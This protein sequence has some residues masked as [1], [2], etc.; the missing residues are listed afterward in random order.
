MRQT[1]R[2]SCAACA[3]SKHSCDLRTPRC[4]RC[5]KRKVLCN[6]ANEPLTAPPA[7]PGQEDN[8][9]IRPLGVSDTLVR[10]RL[11]SLDP[12][13]S[14]PQTRL[15][16]EQVQRLIYSC[17]CVFDSIAG[18]SLAYQSSSPQ[19]R[20]PVLPSRP[21]R[22]IKSVSHLLVATCSRRPSTLSRLATDSMS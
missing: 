19:D 8:E 3:K 7:T 21:K 17:M 12:F 1:L 16:R 15:P 4:S 22:N 6:Y 20:F 9:S 18:Q 10:Y 11:G 13:N 14:Y 5:I 2:R